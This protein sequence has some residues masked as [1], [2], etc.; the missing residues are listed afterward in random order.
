MS[1]SVGACSIQLYCKEN[2]IY[3]I[4]EM[5][6]HGLVPSFHIHVSVSNLYIPTLCPRIHEC[7]NLERGRAVSFLKIHKPN[8]WYIAFAVCI[9]IYA[10]AKR[11]F[12]GGVRCTISIRAVSLLHPF[13]FSTTLVLNSS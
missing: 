7:G 6:L 10:R 5:K 2:P 13:L 9:Y 8:F 11:G 4:P 12:L 1:S 3:L